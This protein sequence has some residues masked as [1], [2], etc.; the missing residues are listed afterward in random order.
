MKCG[1]LQKAVH[2][3]C[4]L[5]L[6]WY[7]RFR[8]LELFIYYIRLL[9]LSVPSSSWITIINAKIRSCV[10]KEVA[11]STQMQTFPSPCFLVATVFWGTLEEPLYPLWD[12]SLLFLY[13]PLLSSPL[14]DT[15]SPHGGRHRWLRLMLKVTQTRRRVDSYW[16]P[17]LEICPHSLWVSAALRYCIGHTMCTSVFS[18][19]LSMWEPW[20]WAKNLASPLQ[21]LHMRT[22]K[23]VCIILQCSL[24]R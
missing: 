10:L 5:N 23:I 12:L 18:F 16:K 1:T 4:S 21:F 6:L 7:L 17:Y 19:G 15:H 13:I 22:F 3:P 8:Q 11:L 14:L 2:L 9:T 24:R 20:L